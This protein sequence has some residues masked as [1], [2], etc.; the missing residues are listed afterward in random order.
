[1]TDNGSA[2]RSHAFRRACAAA[3]LR[4]LRTRPYTP[5]TNGKAERFIQTALREWAYARPY[6]S[7][8]ERSHAIDPWLHHYNHHRP[9]AGI[10]AAH[11]SRSPEQPPWKRHL[12]HHEQSSA[13]P[14]R[15]WLYPSC[16]RL[17]AVHRLCSGHGADVA[18]F[19]FRGRGAGRSIRRNR[20]LMTSPGSDPG[21]SSVR[22]AT[23]A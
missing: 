3:G 18:V 12:G 5:R 14:A 11:P 10:N 7:S 9:H 23:L 19:R 2:Y 16:S 1:M 4:H 15:V 17:R 20:N 8:S 6:A 13:R 21:S 22:A